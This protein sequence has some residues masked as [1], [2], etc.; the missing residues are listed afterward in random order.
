MPMAVVSES[1]SISFMLQIGQKT[2]FRIIREKNRDTVACTFYG[3]ARKAVFTQAYKQ[4]Y[5]GKSA[6]EIP[7]V[8]ELVNVLIALTPSGQTQAGLVDKNT[9][10]YRQ[11][12]AYFKPYLNHPAVTRI[13][14]L[15][16][17]NQ[18]Y[19]IKMD[20]YAYQFQGDALQKSSVFDRISWGEEN[21]LTKHIPLLVDFAQKSGFKA[22][23][24]KHQPYYT[25]LIQ[26]FR[27][28]IDLA[29]MKQ[30]LDKQFPTTRYNCLK[31]VM[32]PLVGANQSANWFEDNGFREAQAHID[33]PVSTSAGTGVER[34]RRQENTFTELNH[35]YENPESDKYGKEVNAAF[36]DMS[37]WTA[38]KA[39][40]SYQNAFSCF[41]EY[42]NWGLVTLYHADHIT[43]AD[44]DVLRKSVEDRMV[45]RRGFAKFREFDQELLR[46][47]QQR[48]PSE[49]V[50]DLYPAILAWAEK[51]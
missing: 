1:D 51:Q 37:K 8:Y 38:G 45:N 13:D 48:K 30:W 29:S 39:S 32:S 42:M 36:G 20:S 3:I 33:V 10:Y 28:T 4:A 5:E 40:A 47:Y 24:R 34:A 15:L 35:A 26:G 25:N 21:T 31:I 12:M 9:G 49:T 22:F 41:Q 43:G 6:V 14:S 18:Y 19:P 11:V 44:F 17:A 16:K 50:A 23:Y 7:D 46:L 2:R 27:Q